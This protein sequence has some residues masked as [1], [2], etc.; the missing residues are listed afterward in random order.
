MANYLSLEMINQLVKAIAST[1]MATAQVRDDL[2][3]SIDP[4]YV[5]SLPLRNNPMDQIRSDLTLLNGVSVLA[6][7]QVPLCIWLTNAHHRMQ[8]GQR[9]E[10]ALFK[11]VLDQVSNLSE[12]R[13]QAG[14]LTGEAYPPEIYL[15]YSA[16]DNALA[17]SL[18]HALQGVGIA[19]WRERDMVQ[20]GDHISLQKEQA[21]RRVDAVI[22]L[23]TQAAKDST[24]VRNEVLFALDT[25]REIIP[26]LLQPDVTP[27]LDIY[28]LQ[29]VPMHVDWDTGVQTLVE[30]LRGLATTR[31]AE[32]RPPPRT[33]PSEATQ[34]L[35]VQVHREGDPFLYGPAVPS[36]LFVGRQ[37]ELN[38]IR[39]RVG[40]EGGLQ[41]LSIVANRR[42]GKTSLLKYVWKEWQRI[43]HSDQQYATV[44][45]DAM[46]ARAHTIEGVM[47]I[48]RRA[49]QRQLDMNLWA[50]Q[51]DGRLPLLDEAF[52]DLANQDVCLV[53][54][55]DEWESV[56]AY[57]ELDAL[58]KQL[59]SSGSQGYIGLITATAHKLSDLS[60]QGGFVSE[61]YNIFDTC[62]L[63]NMPRSEWEGLIGTGFAR[64]GRTPEPQVYDL[65][66]ELAGGHPYLTQLAGSLAWQAEA[67]GWDEEEVRQRFAQGAHDLFRNLAAPE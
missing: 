39:R 17:Q 7:G 50:E 55:L 35:A 49:V 16:S 29:P 61:F 5:G 63:G 44:Y 18:R 65:I 66:G 24:R 1:Q 20:P 64:S 19:V 42:M 23:V 34:P 37:A 10:Q 48:V 40:H 25:Q 22:V 57:P 12:A 38:A 56:M 8:L 46:G 53:L 67:E 30:R 3:S 59:R 33:P 26:V 4:G 45:I 60:E 31:T 28:G 9:T 62:Y 52:E 43:F 2:L 15:C 14:Q 32:V 58:L 51:D 47:R 36:H 11:E 54:L 13:L 41:S 21:I 6:N 27:M